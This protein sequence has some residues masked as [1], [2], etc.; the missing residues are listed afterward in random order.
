MSI[1]YP[2][3]FPS[4][5]LWVWQS[6]VRDWRYFCWIDSDDGWLYCRYQSYQWIGYK[7]LNVHEL[8]T[9]ADKGHICCKEMGLCCVETRLYCMETR[10]CCIE[11]LLYLRGNWR[12]PYKWYKHKDLP[13]KLF[14]RSWPSACQQLS[15]N[16]SLRNLSTQHSR[17][18]MQQRWPISATVTY[19]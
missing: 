5:T 12:C 13:W 16:I 4:H 6:V 3:S 17:I 18:S 1:S 14:V 2:G 7:A 15:I 9:V 10:L 8:T 19:Q 11:V